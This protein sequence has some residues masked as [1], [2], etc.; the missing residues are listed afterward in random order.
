MES[1]QAQR[2]DRDIR[3]SE[4]NP[5]TAH[6]L[7]GRNGF[8]AT[9]LCRGGRHKQRAQCVRTTTAACDSLVP[10]TGKKPRGGSLSL[11]LLHTDCSPALL[12]FDARTWCSRP[13][14]EKV[15]VDESYRRAMA[16]LRDKLQPT[17]EERT[18]AEERQRKQSKGQEGF[19]RGGVVVV[20]RMRPEGDRRS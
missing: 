3:R 17:K 6:K 13:S 11:L 12:S 18:G 16:R 4:L 15:V 9:P 5:P 8:T 2:G 10:E 14:G 7:H 20:A 1:E 19:G